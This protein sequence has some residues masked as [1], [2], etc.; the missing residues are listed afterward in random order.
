M[1]K[2]INIDRPK[3]SSKDINSRQDFSSVL[4]QFNAFV[5]P[6]IYKTGWFITTIAGVA[7]IVILS[8]V[9]LLSSNPTADNVAAVEQ[10]DGSAPQVNADT[11]Q[12]S[13]NLLSYSEDSP[14]VKPPVAEFNIPATIYLIDA[15]KGGEIIH[16]TGTKIIIPKNAFVDA[17][18]NSLTGDVNLEFREFHNP[19]DIMLAG[20]PMHYDSAGLKMVLESDG[21][22]ELVGFQNGVRVEIADNKTI[23][24]DVVASQQDSRFNAYYLDEDNEQWNYKGKPELVM[25]EQVNDFTYSPESLI[26][27]LD[28]GTL[29][30]DKN[31]AEKAYNSA[32]KEVTAYKKLEP[33]KPASEGD[34]TRQFALDVDP[35]EFPELSA[36]KSLD[37]EVEKQ[38]P[39]FSPSVY[40]EQWEGVKLTE[41]VKGKLYNLTLNRPGLATT[42]SVFPVFKGQDLKTAMAK[43]EKQYKSYE[44]Q[45]QT[46]LDT[47]ETAKQEFEDK[48]EAWNDARDQE[49]SILKSDENKA[50]NYA[51]LEVIAKK[52]QVTKF[53]TWN[54]DCGIN[55]PNGRQ[56]DASF[57]DAAGNELNLGAVNLFEKGKNTL[58]TYN[59]ERFGK[60]NY[61]PS[62]DNM[63]IAFVDDKIAIVNNAQISAIEDKKAKFVMELKEIT[64][65]LIQDLKILARY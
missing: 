39:N 44:K 12:K 27:R 62:E 53:G 4:N 31:T 9:Y 54:V 34:K 29:E 55:L 59:K 61:D 47:E 52:L 2:K 6:P 49:L 65:M 11:T 43:F 25:K 5:K 45:L 8:S 60:L 40:K 18:G 57:V 19:I 24:I 28:L 38:D 41:K 15:V 42:L 30:T 3:V 36:Y 16:S 20:I 46:R 14:C 22:I 7:G 21:M 26:N 17:E 33:K 37:F 64:P 51:K 63:I 56:L 13:E 48:L 50:S 23:E 1:K 35:K 58:Y 32:V 10:N